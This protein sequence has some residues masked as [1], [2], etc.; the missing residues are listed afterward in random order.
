MIGDTPRD[1]AAAQAI[2]ADC[3]AVTTGFYGAEALGEAGAAWVVDRLDTPDAL[4]AIA[5]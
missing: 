2:G 3:L 1:V 4:R 5:L